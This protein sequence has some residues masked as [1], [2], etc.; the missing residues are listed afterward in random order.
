MEVIVAAVIAG[1]LSLA[2]TVL[3]VSRSRKASTDQHVAQT[4]HLTAIQANQE[5]MLGLITAHRETA[6]L[7]LQQ[8]H[9]RVDRL[10]LGHE[11]LF[12]MLVDVDRKVTKQSNKRKVSAQNLV[13]ETVDV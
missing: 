2:G 3:T 7:Q 10:A 9:D 4:S 12:T 11:T 1:V 8:V 6:E 5:V 13:V